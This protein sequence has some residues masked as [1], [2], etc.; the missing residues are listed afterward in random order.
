MTKVI[1]YK[2]SLRSDIKNH[3]RKAKVEPDTIIKNQKQASSQEA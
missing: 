1:K 3:S 2:I